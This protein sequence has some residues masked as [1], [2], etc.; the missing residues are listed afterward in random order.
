[1][2]GV[3]VVFL[4]VTLLGLLPKAVFAVAPWDDWNF[5]PP[6]AHPALLLEARKHQPKE[7]HGIASG[8]AHELAGP[9]C[10]AASTCRAPLVVAQPCLPRGTARLRPEATGPPA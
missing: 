1:M 4:V 2:R 3:R 5:A 8:E 10:T 7:P 6:A 9:K